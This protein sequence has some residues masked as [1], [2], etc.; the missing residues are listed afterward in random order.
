MGLF[1]KFKSGL[2]K[3][4]QKLVHEMTRIVTRSP[5]LTGSSLEELQSAL[6]GADLGLAMTE[7]ILAAVRRA[8]ETQ[9]TAGLDV[10]AVATAEV[11]RSLGHNTN[12]LHK[13]P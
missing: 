8:Y 13:Q 3:T 7:E 10:F 1:D 4:H 12:S 9:G 2:Q 6:I 11:E 5:R